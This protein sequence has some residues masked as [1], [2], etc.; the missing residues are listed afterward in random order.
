MPSSSS[1]R[2]GTPR[3]ADAAQS[4]PKPRFKIVVQKA[5]APKGRGSKG[6]GSGRSAGPPRRRARGRVAGARA[7]GARSAARAPRG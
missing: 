3:R 2:C 1:P 7:P 4:V 5:S 6:R